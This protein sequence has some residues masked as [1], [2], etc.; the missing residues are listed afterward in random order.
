[1]KLKKLLEEANYAMYGGKMPTGGKTS[2]LPMH[3]FS[4]RVPKMPVFYISVN[5]DTRDRAEDVAKF[6]LN[7]KLRGYYELRDETPE[8]VGDN[9]V[10]KIPLNPY[11]GTDDSTVDSGFAAD[12]RDE[13]PPPGI[14]V[15]EYQKP[16][17]R[18]DSQ[19]VDLKKWWEYD[20]GKVM[21]HIYGIKNRAVPSDPAILKNAWASIR[22]QL[23]ALYPPPAAAGNASNLSEESDAEFDKT[24]AQLIADFKEFYSN[25][26]NFNKKFV[27]LQQLAKMDKSAFVKRYM[28]LTQATKWDLPNEIFRYLNETGLNAGELTFDISKFID[29]N[30]PPKL[31]ED[32]LKASIT[33]DLNMG[34][35]QLTNRINIVGK[36]GRKAIKFNFEKMDDAIPGWIYKSI[37]GKYTLIIINDYQNRSL[38]NVDWKGSRRV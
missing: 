5:S 36:G 38:S 6:S 12:M 19:E 10:V 32:P 23:A 27:E 33:K 26:P 1:M 29:R 15:S 21:S 4:V 18:Y 37:D 35:H 22:T 31:P 14:G 8:T 30:A 16:A 34:G 9:K 17:A 2:D 11:I 3:Y 13:D 20:P 24:A 7:R 25:T 28:R